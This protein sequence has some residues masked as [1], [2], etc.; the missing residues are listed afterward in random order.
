MA[1]DLLTDRLSVG[2]AAKYVTEG[3]EFASNSWIAG[4]IS[5]QF[6]TGIFSTT[7][8]ASI[9]NLGTSSRWEGS[10]LIQNISS[11]RDVFPTTRDIQVTFSPEVAPFLV[12]QLPQGES[13]RPLRGIIR[14]HIEDPL[15]TELLEHGSEEP[16]LVTIEDDRTIFA[17]PVPLV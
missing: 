6:R 8:G 9:Q 10:R 3:V 16:L 2:F 4:D 7:L 12:D 11:A 14:E 17:R 1:N 15:S 5:T 13:V